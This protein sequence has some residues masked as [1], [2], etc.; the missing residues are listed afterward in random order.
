MASSAGSGQGARRTGP[1]LVSMY[2]FVLWPVPTVEKF[3]RRQKFLLGDRLQATA[4]DVLERL[5]EATYTRA[6]RLTAPRLGLD[7][8]LLD[9]LPD[10]GGELPPVPGRR[11][12]QRGVLR[13][14]ERDLTLR[15]FTT[16]RARGVRRPVSRTRCHDRE[17]CASTGVPASGTPKSWPYGRPRTVAEHPPAPTRRVSVSRSPP[18][19]SA[20]RDRARRSPG[21][22]RGCGVFPGPPWSRRA[23][24]RAPTSEDGARAAPAPARCAAR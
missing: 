17:A 14:V 10:D 22:S 2:R 24:R 23:P 15:V 13:F 16:P 18:D 21:P 4:L 9:C 11:P 3:P 8:V 12:V 7:T 6:R 20:P 19:R 1:A 5:V